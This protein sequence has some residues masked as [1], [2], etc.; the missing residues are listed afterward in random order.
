MPSQERLV[1]KCFVHSSI[2]ALVIS[3]LPVDFRMR[4]HD[5][6][7][8]ALE[9]VLPATVPPVD[10]T[11][12]RLN[13]AIF[14]VDFSYPKDEGTID[15]LE[16]II[17]HCVR[18]GRLEYAVEVYD[19]QLGGF[20]HLGGELSEYRRGYRICSVLALGLTPREL[21]RSS[22]FP[23]DLKAFLVNEW[24]LYALHLVELYEALEFFQQAETQYRHEKSWSGISF[25]LQNQTAVSIQVGRIGDAIRFAC[26]AV[27]AAKRMDS[28]DLAASGVLERSYHR[29]AQ[30]LAWRGKSRWALEFFAH[31]LTIRGSLQSQIAAVVHDDANAESVDSLK[32]DP[33]ESRP[34]SWSVESLKRSFCVKSDRYAKHAITAWCNVPLE[35][36]RSSLSSESDGAIKSESHGAIVCWN[37]ARAGLALKQAAKLRVTLEVE[38]DEALLTSARTS[39]R[40]GLRIA[41]TKAFGL[42]FADL[43]LLR[44]RL[45]LMEG[46]TD[47]VFSL[48]AKITDPHAK[49][50]GA[51]L[52]ASHPACRYEWAIADAMMPAV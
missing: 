42:Y 6:V 20:H 46:D 49:L 23:E 33:T 14:M 5:K 19:R 15:V 13:R 51:L 24:G 12:L 22:E 11:T 30:A 44:A 48:L 16:A 2:A 35:E 29:L 50:D 17:W 45:S 27:R 28:N 39:I 8:T 37:W 41:T 34:P 7:R 38:N 40:E 36:F 3:R 4:F 52:P 18:A 21:C 9:S 43:T 26:E 25:S 47:S 1:R 31:V 32:N 10:R